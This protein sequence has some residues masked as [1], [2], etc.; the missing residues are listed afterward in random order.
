MSYQGGNGEIILSCSFSLLPA[1]LLL[2]AGLFFFKALWICQLLC[3]STT[4]LNS[5]EL[6]GLAG[7]GAWRE[8]RTHPPTHSPT[9]LL[10]HLLSASDFLVLGLPLKQRIGRQTRKEEACDDGS[11]RGDTREGS[12]QVACWVVGGVYTVTPISSSFSPR[13]Q[14][15]MR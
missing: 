2:V 8:Q 5:F 15:I 7:S 11:T 13:G 10:P 4:E 1:N 14:G 9:L 3:Q 12:T 6:A